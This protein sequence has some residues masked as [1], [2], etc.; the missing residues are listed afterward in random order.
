MKK[1]PFCAE[2]IR[3][4]AVKCRYCGEFFDRFRSKT[5]TSSLRERWYFKTSVLVLG[6]LVFGPLALPLLWMNPRYGRKAKTIVSLIVLG[7]TL[8]S[9]VLLNKAAQSLSSYYG[10]AFPA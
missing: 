9:W 10:M 6:I 1:C 8:A 4:E 2:E 7:L 5:E 3:D